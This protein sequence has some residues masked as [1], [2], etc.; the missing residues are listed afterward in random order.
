MNYFIE[1]DKLSATET[2]KGALLR[3]ANT[4]N[5][6]IAY[7]DMK[8]G[9]EIPMHNHLEEAVDIILEGI[10]EMQ[11]GEKTDT[12]TYGMASIVPSNVPHK[13]HAITNCKVV[14]IFYP[15]RKL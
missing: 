11:I 6:T 1:L 8:A 4:E 3:S 9:V 2:L 14:T 5:L 12:L 10:L 13:A 7:T 15:K